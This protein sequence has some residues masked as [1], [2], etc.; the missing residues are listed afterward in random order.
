MA[1]EN[2][3]Y[4]PYEREAIVVEMLTEE[5]RRWIDAYH[6]EV[7]QTLSP[8]VSDDTAAWLAEACKPL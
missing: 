1:H 2:I 5:E 3:T 8:L 6:A 4:C 7:L